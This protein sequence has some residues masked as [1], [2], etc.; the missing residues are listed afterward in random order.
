MAMNEL[1]GTSDW[2]VGE[3]CR[4]YLMEPD[5]LEPLVAEFLNENPYADA[6]ALAEHFVALGLL[7]RYQID[8]IIEGEVKSLL[9]GPYILSEPIGTGSMGTVFRAIGKADKQPY[10]V[11][12]LPLRS[13]WNVRMARRQVRSFVDLPAHP[14]IVTFVDVGTALNKHYLV[15]PL[16]EGKTLDAVAKERGPLPWAEAALI[17]LRL[18]EG[19][20][21]CH[22]YSL[23]HGLIKPS[24]IM[25]G[26]DGSIR[27]L[28]F[29]IGALLAENTD[30]SLLDT[31]S[32]ANATAGM[33]DCTSPESILD[34]A[35]R[36]FAGD[37]YSLG[38]I[39]YFALTARYPYPEGNMVDKMLA[40]QMMTPEPIHLFNPE[41]P[42][43]LIAIV[44]RLMQKVPESRF[45]EI[46]EVLHEL[47]LLVERSGVAQIAMPAISTDTPVRVT[48]LDDTPSMT[49]A[50]IPSLPELPPL[51]KEPE[52]AAAAAPSVQAPIALELPAPPPLPSAA[53][54][55]LHPPPPLRQSVFSR[56]FEK[57]VFWRSKRDSVQVSILAPP[58]LALNETVT[59]PIFAHCDT[60]ENILAMGRTYFPAHQVVATTPL[61]REITRGSRIT[62]HLALPGIT[63]EQPVQKFVW[64]GQT[65]PLPYAVK[66]PADC[67]PG[68]I[69]GIVS[70]GEGS[71]IIANLEFQVLIGE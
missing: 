43:E 38:C 53:P 2:L 59:L 12:V 15:W 69:V 24:N 5:Q 68:E 61:R 70:I 19:L 54:T 22:R 46:G 36:S 52:S 31:M 65:M 40:H 44:E 10:A 13:I 20:Q 41:T 66:V 57:L 35:K 7:T 48:R 56:V 60:P 33:L 11:K 62:F 16:A 18:A 37:Q 39:L 26:S 34:P 51:P 28:D 45:R 64:R 6:T 4:S 8:R 47:H 9:L 17:A 71:D 3:L 27:L 58:A 29:G 23:F 55:T 42:P 63:V 25:L 32:T 14:A 1:V 67:R 50:K 21:L 30:E 49:S